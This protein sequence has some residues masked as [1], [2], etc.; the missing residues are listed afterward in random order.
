MAIRYLGIDWGEKRWG[1]AYA[2]ELGVATPLDAITHPEPEVRWDALRRAIVQRRIEVCV[3]GYPYNMDGTV[4]FKAKEV[5]AFIAQLEQ[6]F[7]GVEVHRVDERL[8]SH[9]AG[10]GWSERQKRE[11]RRSGKLD[12]SA[13]AIILQDF[14]DQLP[15]HGGWPAEEG[16]A[17]GQ[18]D[19][20]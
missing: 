2:D 17:E 19:G 3:V 20:G 4:G 14:V 16:L 6:R 13:A 11:Q 8:T 12:S 7:P 1:L 18:D 15:P 5:D 10:L 9:V